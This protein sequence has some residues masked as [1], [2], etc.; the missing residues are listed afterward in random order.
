[1]SLFPG[2]FFYCCRGFFFPLY[3]LLFSFT[4]QAQTITF[5]NFSRPVT[6]IKEQG[7]YRL[8]GG[9]HKVTLTNRLIIKTDKAISK[10]QLARYHQQISRV[11]E[12]F[13]A[14]H[15]RYYL[16]EIKDEALL[17]EV[18]SLLRGKVSIELVQPDI[19]QLKT[20]AGHNEIA[21]ASEQ[22][23]AEA[24]AKAKNKSNAY[25]S[26][27]GIDTLWQQSKG[28]GV[29]LAIIDDGFALKH[30]DLQA[31]KVI[32]SYDVTRRQLSVA[33]RSALDSHGTKVAGIIFAEHNNIGIMGIAPEAELI[34]I[35]QPDSWSS[36][37][38][39]SFQ[40]ARLAGADIINCS[41]HSNWLLQP[42]AEITDDLTNYGR[43]G[44]GIAVIFSAGNQG[45]AIQPLSNEAT[46][47]SAIVVGA[48]DQNGQRM[49]YSNH[50]ET[51]DILSYGKNSKTTL[52]SRKYGRF[53]GTSLAAAIT[54]GLSALLL[55]IQPEI[56]T[57]QLL[58]Q[59]TLLTATGDS[60]N[61]MAAEKA[62]KK[63]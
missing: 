48:A 50:G 30:P 34:A 63:K 22:F 32:F 61:G 23:I 3:I 13:T 29:K 2:I 44:K 42:V 19:L 5:D 40:L 56:T 18:L 15:S 52:I 12:L 33:P 24:K 16:A 36:N 31:T 41:W 39:L 27:F 51:V 54:S 10:Q 47:A 25:I 26:L 46:I 43:N 17:G 62:G 4:A 37:T 60:Q 53:S 45:K 49:A 8:K 14:E 55:S 7:F 59:L 58:Q 6:L 9:E 57:E 35:R 21:P 20:H 1:M 28:A 11:S 38:L